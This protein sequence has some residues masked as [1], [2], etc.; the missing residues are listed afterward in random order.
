MKLPSSVRIMAVLATLSFTSPIAARAETAG[1]TCAGLM[2]YDA[3]DA[4]VCM[5]GDLVSQMRLDQ[6][7]EV[8]ARIESS[9]LKLASI[10]AAYAKA[11]ADENDS[12]AAR[13]YYRLYKEKKDIS[14]GGETG[15]SLGSIV[16]EIGMIAAG[17]AAIDSKRAALERL[18]LRLRAFSNTGRFPD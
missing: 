13:L 12:R 8:S 18:S 3:N 7:E 5:T 15:E 16:G 6:L 2:Y 4:R 14:F 1:A 17:N 9:A 10:N 11:F